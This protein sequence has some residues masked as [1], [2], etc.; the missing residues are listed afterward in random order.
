M[1]PDQALVDWLAWHRAGGCTFTDAWLMSAERACRD[2]PDFWRPW[3]EQTKDIWRRAYERE[4]ARAW[5]ME[6]AAQASDLE[7]DDGH[8][9]CALCDEPIPAYRLRHHAEFCSEECRK[10]ASRARERERLRAAA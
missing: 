6:F 9:R 4:P 5:E 8:P 1:R 7:L 10:Q 3:L 2:A